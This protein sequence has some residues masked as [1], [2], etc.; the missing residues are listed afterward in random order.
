MLS[1]GEISVERHRGKEP[2]KKE[3]RL[4]GKTWC[5][6]GVDEGTVRT[7]KYMDPKYVGS[8][9]KNKLTVTAF[10]AHRHR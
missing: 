3:W 7:G 4:L 2:K 6:R 10:I 8:K 1:Y 5:T 9:A